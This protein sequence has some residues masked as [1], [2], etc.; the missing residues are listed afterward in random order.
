MEKS[1]DAKT[2]AKKSSD[3]YFMENLH[4]M[5]NRPNLLSKIGNEG[6]PFTDAMSRKEDQDESKDI[7][8]ILDRLKNL[9]HSFS[10]TSFHGGGMN[11]MQLKSKIHEKVKQIKPR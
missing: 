8:T 1:V 5:F 10:G 3:K 11:L 2:M 7:K 9:F 4:L 6:R